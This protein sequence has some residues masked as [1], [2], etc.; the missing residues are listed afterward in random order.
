MSSSIPADAR[1][2]SRLIL[3]TFSTEV[4]WYRIMACSLPRHPSLPPAA[5]VVCCG[6]ALARQASVHAHRFANSDLAQSSEQRHFTLA[7]LARE[8]SLVIV[9]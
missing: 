8:R 2:P 9:V 1:R 7:F 6:N 5:S 3:S 4:K